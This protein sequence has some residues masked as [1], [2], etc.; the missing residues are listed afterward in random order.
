MKIPK[1]T[2]NKVRCIWSIMLGSEDEGANYKLQRKSLAFNIYSYAN[3]VILSVT[4]SLTADHF[5]RFLLL[6]IP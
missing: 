4:I 5:W 6:S 2:F 3:L 1:T